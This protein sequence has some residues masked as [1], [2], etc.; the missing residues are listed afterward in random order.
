M[1]PDDAS[2][3]P[4][5]LDTLFEL[6][7]DAVLVTDAQ[8]HIRGTNEQAEAMFGYGRGELAASRSRTWFRS[9]SGSTIRPIAKDTTSIRAPARWAAD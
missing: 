4:K 2:A 5:A 3:F 6:S 8:G 7:P 9:V 1:L